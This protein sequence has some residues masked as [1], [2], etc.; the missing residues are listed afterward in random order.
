[1]NDTAPAPG[2]RFAG[3][4]LARRERVDHRS[5][6]H[7]LAA[8]AAADLRRRGGARHTVVDLGAGGGSNLRYLIGHL[9]ARLPEPVDWHLLD[10]DAGL[11]A[12]ALGE[13]RPEARAGDRVAGAVCDLAEPLA[14]HLAGA[15]LVT[16]SALLDLVSLDWIE[17]FVAA[18]AATRAAVLVA[19]SVDGRIEFD[20]PDPAD[21]LVRHA[22]AADQRRDK[23]FGPALGG[24]A[25]AALVNALAHAGYGVD[26]RPSDWRL[27]ARDMLLV[28]PLIDG[29][30]AAAQRQRPKRRAAIAA[31]AARRTAAIAAGRTRLTVGHVDVLGL[32]NPRHLA[33]ARRGAD[34]LLG[35][36]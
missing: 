17:G 8:L 24:A 15:G 22:V 1:M 6:A 34:P 33:W 13:N 16:A 2:S 11:L 5:R 4:W 32:P 30:R 27:D 7:G 3:D 14:P 28:D 29:W 10:H 26:T 12:T 31:W 25:P 35:P 9:A 19:M 20:D 36:T 18:C 23:G 21:D